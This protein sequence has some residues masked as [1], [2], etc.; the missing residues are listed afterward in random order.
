MAGRQR[1][2]RPHGLPKPPPL[3]PR[4]TH[5]QANGDSTYTTLPD[6]LKPVVPGDEKGREGR[7]GGH[8][9]DTGEEEGRLPGAPGG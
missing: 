3:P 5:I 6:M 7:G 9:G 8:I 2:L 4:P 1:R